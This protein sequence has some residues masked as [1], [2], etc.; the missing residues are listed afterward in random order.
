MPSAYRLQIGGRK[1]WSALT[2]RTRTRWCCERTCRASPHSGNCWPA[3]RRLSPAAYDHQDLP[4]EKLFEELD[5]ERHLDRSPLFQVLFHLLDFPDGRPA[6]QGLDEKWPPRLG[7]RVHCDLEMYLLTQPDQGVRGSVVY[8]ADLFE[9][10][11]IERL[12]GHFKTLLAGIVADP[13]MRIEQLPLLREA[14][15]RQLLIEWNDTAC[16]YP[17]DRCVHQLFEEQ[18]NRTP[19]AVA[20]VFEE[21]QLTYRELNAKANQL[22]AICAAWAS[23]P[24]CWWASAS[25]ARWRW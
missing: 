23:V 12:A 10:A 20:V 19:D 4:F 25:N 6:P 1:S 24:R 3:P 22:R 17:R 16:D 18:A 21:R 9:A 8:N 11:T 15:R 13:D 2:D 14:E 7:G 5:P